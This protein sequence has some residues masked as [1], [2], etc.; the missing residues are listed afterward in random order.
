MRRRSIGQFG[1]IAALV[2]TS[3]CVQQTRHS[4]LM[5]FGTNTSLGI[6][7]GT[8]PSQVPSIVVGYD[9]QE[10]VL[11]PLLANTVDLEKSADKTNLLS[12]CPISPSGGSA[13]T[14][15]CLFAAR[16]GDAVDAY[17]VLASF[18]ANFDA[19]NSGSNVTAKGGLAQYFST[20]MAAQI[21]AMTGG[22]S[23]VAVGEAAKKSAETAPSTAPAAASLFGKPYIPPTPAQIAQYDSVESQYAQFKKDFLSRLIN[24]PDATYKTNITT[25]ENNMLLGTELSQECDTKIDCIRYFD[26]TSDIWKSYFT[27]DGAK[28]AKMIAAVPTL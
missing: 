14:H 13:S 6:K 12:P 21:L 11:L 10:A 5:V 28:R 18:G 24:L 3:G 8:A 7:V 9:R 1:A 22:A 19:G 17:S 27:L 2:L 15:P 23:V 4:N 20:G 26:Q 16:R 25:F